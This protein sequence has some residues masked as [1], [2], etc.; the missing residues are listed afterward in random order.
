MLRMSAY[1]E[2]NAESVRS[3]PVF[4]RLESGEKSTFAAIAPGLVFLSFTWQEILRINAERAIDPI[5]RAICTQARADERHH[6]RW[7]MHDLTVLCPSL[8]PDVIWLFDHEQA[9]GRD[10]CYDLL[11]EATQCTD[12]WMRVTLMMA[13]EAASKMFFSTMVPILVRRGWT[14]KLAYYS[15]HHL[16]SEYAHDIYHDEFHARLEAHPLG[17]EEHVRHRSLVQRVHAAL[18]IV[19]DEAALRAELP[20]II[21]VARARRPSYVA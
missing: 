17:N 2:L 21:P 4:A 8:R 12:D 7:L 11:A 15:E 1:C 18:G 14:E 10:A 19:F 13:I 3:H 9:R 20:V 6:D 5:V 16:E